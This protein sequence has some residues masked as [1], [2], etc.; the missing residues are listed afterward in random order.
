M[1]LLTE[2][3]CDKCTKKRTLDGQCEV[4][5]LVFSAY[6]RQQSP[7]PNGCFYARVRV[8]RSNILNQPY[9]LYYED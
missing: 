7:S 6:H 1:H 2:V 9:S 4:G 5:A 8:L 3:I